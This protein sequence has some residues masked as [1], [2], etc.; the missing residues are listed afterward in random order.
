[1]TPAEGELEDAPQRWRP[2][3]YRAAKAFMDELHRTSDDYRVPT[4]AWSGAVRAGK[5][6]AQAEALA[7]REAATAAATT[8]PKFVP[9]PTPQRLT[10]RCAGTTP[11]DPLG[12]GGRRRPCPSTVTYTAVWGDDLPADTAAAMRAA[13]WDLHPGRTTPLV[14]HCPNTHEETR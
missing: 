2:R 7:G 6:H 14:W 10:M 4:H 9:P 8:V 11:G 5:T 1:V 3:G 12:L 13:G